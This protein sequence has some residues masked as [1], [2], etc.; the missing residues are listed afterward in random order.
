MAENNPLIAER[1]ARFLLF[2]LLEAE[3]LCGLPHF[4]DHSRQTFELYVQAAAKL[5]REVV[6]PTYKPMDAEPLI[7]R[8]GA[9]TRT[10]AWPSCIRSWSSSAC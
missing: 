8:T 4:A 10:R 5:A 7:T 9:C 2:E 1:E 6:L 3:T